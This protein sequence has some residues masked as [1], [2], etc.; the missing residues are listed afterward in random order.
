M[1]QEEF[2]ELCAKG[3]YDQITDAL[4]SGIAPDKP[5][6]IDGKAVHPFFVA[7]SADNNDAVRALTEH[8][9]DPGIPDSNGRTA[10]MIAAIDEEIDPGILET[11]LGFGADI[12]A[13]DK[14]GLTALM[15]AVSAV[16]RFPD[17][18]M[19]ALIR[20]GALRAEGWQEWFMFDAFYRLARHQ[21]QT[22]RVR[23]LV[24]KGADVNKTDKRGMNALMYAL[25]NG[26]DE[27]ADILTEAGAKVTFDIN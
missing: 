24:D 26:D 27:S 23:Y 10:L 19:P 4:D 14:D 25:A 21:A 7:V 8:G 12:D 9:A 5:V 2:L 1:T 16:D 11:L 6:M 15:W 18:L 13:S 20:T 17:L 22:D 3:S